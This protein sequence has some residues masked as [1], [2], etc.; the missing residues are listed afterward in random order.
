MPQV[1]RR[2]RTTKETAIVGESL[3]GL[4]VV[5][6][7][8]LEPDLFDTYIAI[9]PSVWWNNQQLVHDAAKHLRARPELK[10]ALYL[11]SSSEEWT[12]G[13]MQQFVDVL[14]KNAPGGV[15]WRYAQMPEEKHATIYHPA[16]LKAF[17]E[18][19]KPIQ[20]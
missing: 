17:R 3:A 7:L 19:F 14:K 12:P 10:K 4:F 9:D 2:Y 13:L 1:K 11:A 20:K 16:A 5:E 8:L 6:T 15:H 18:M